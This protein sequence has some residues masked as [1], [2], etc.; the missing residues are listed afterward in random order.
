MFEARGLLAT[1]FL[2]ASVPAVAQESLAVIALRDWYSGISVDG[3]TE[4]GLTFKAFHA[5]DGRISAV[6][7]GQYRNTGTWKIVEPGQVC[8]IWSDAAWGNNPCYTVFKDGESWRLVRVDDPRVF[9]K[10][11]RVEGNPF[12]L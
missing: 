12:G 10:V 1:V 6:A 7:D 11:R 9:A 2:L 8:I 4:K 3:H 5:P